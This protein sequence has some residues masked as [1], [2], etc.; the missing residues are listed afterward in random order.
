MRSELAQNVLA[1]LEGVLGEAPVGLHN[2]NFSGREKDYLLDCI[3]STFVSSVGP[4]VTQFEKDLQNFTGAEFAVATMNGTAALHI[5]LLLAGVKP[6]QEVLIPSLTF[7][8]TANAVIYCGAIPHFVASEQKTLGIDADELRTYLKKNTQRVRKECVNILTGRVVSALVPMHTFGHPSNLRDLVEVASDFNL[9]LIEDA[10]ESLGS[11]YEGNHTGTFGALGTLSF[12]GNKIVTTGGGG[13]ILTNDQ[14][15][16]IR[17]KHLTTTAKLPHAW[18]F[19]HDKVGF[20]YRMPNINAA[21]G[22]AQLEEIESKLTLKRNLFNRYESKFREVSGVTLFKEPQNSRSNYWLQTLVLDESESSLRDE[23]LQVTNNA[24]YTTRPAWRLLADLDPF[25][26]CPSMP[27]ETTRKLAQRLI[28]L[29]SN[30]TR[31]PQA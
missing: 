29:P 30:P 16:A 17:A 20:N 6:D 27:L 31:I 3:D 5:A 13:A 4:Y 8:A 14:E 7:V 21:V 12:N 2:P 18:E 28:N 1:T 10:A 15:L 9:K 19:I 23:I 25:K 26:A 24:G 22:C 11:Y